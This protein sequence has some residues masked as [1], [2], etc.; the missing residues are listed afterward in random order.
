MYSH[1]IM[2]VAVDCEVNGKVKGRELEMTRSARVIV[3]PRNAKTLA[4]R[5]ML[6]TNS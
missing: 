3:L 5:R 6:T 1:V 4:Y 2:T